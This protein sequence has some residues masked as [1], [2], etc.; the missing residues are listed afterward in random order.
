MRVASLGTMRLLINAWAGLQTQAQIRTMGQP[1]NS[2]FHYKLGL[3]LKSAP[4]T[5]RKTHIAAFD[6][7]S[8]NFASSFKLVSDES[9]T[10]FPIKPEGSNC[11]DRRPP[12]PP[13][14]FKS[15]PVVGAARDPV[16]GCRSLCW[17]CRL[18]MWRP[19]L[20]WWD[21]V[22]VPIDDLKRGATERKVEKE[23]NGEV[24]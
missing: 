23:R 8:L 14:F 12:T 10:A 6:T 13:N 7:L 2:H 20:S 24:L 5:T 15:S 11:P 1:Q 21:G 22:R 18:D 19:L 9:Y 17:S 16:V 3:G 4:A